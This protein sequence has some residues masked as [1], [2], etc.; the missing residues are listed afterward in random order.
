MNY[1]FGDFQQ[2]KSILSLS[3]FSSITSVVI[4]LSLWNTWGW[5]LAKVKPVADVAGINTNGTI[6]IIK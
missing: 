3:S 5:L 6:I 2:W 1:S 4:W